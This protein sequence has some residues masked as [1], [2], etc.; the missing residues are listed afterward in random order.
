MLAT[1]FFSR[2]SSST[3]MAF[4]TASDAF[5]EPSRTAIASTIRRA[6]R[7]PEVVILFRCNNL[8]EYEENAT[9]DNRSEDESDEIIILIVRFIICS[10]SFVIFPLTSITVTKSIGALRSVFVRIGG[11]FALRQIAYVS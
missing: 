3:L 7:W 10:F 9:I 2:R 1:V 4:L 11:A 5:D 6:A 8:L